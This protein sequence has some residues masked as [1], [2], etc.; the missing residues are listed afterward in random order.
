MIIGITLILRNGFSV[1]FGKGTLEITGFRHDVLDGQI[2][3]QSA[4]V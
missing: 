2:M 1:L 3:T 4:L